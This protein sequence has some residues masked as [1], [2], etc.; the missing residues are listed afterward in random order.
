[1]T[2]ASETIYHLIIVRTLLNEMYAVHLLHYGMHRKPIDFIMI[3]KYFFKCD[4]L[5]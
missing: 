5:F 4:Y 3:N 1:M 2:Y